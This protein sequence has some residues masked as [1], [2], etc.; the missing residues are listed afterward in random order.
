MIP[1]QV[2]VAY[3]ELKAKKLFPIHWGMFQLG[4]H[5]WDEPPKRLLKAVKNSNDFVN[6]KIGT[7]YDLK[8]WP[9]VDRWW[10]NY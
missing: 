10:E 1:E 4:F 7:L 3:K 9:A 5:S 2:A 8:K 6:P